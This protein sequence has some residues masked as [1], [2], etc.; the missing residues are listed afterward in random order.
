[1]DVR[2]AAS[3]VHRQP[4]RRL[5]GR[6]STRLLKLAST[7]IAPDELNGRA[8][9]FSPHPDDE[10]LGC[11]GTILKKV[12]SGATVTLVHMTDGGASTDL[13]AR[14]ELVAMRKREC[15]SA[16]RV[17]GVSDTIF[18]EYADG[19]LWDSI[20]PATD[21]V[22]EI[23][24][25]LQPAQVF[26]PYCREPMKQAADHVA[27]TKIVRAALERVGRS[28]TVWEYPIWAWLHWPWVRLRQPGPLMRTKHVLWN[29]GYLLF[30]ARSL[31][32]WRRRVEIA[33]VLDE[34]REAIAQHRSQTERI[35]AHPGYM[36]LGDVCHG[37]FLEWFMQ[38][39]EYFRVYDYP[40]GR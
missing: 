6:A 13:I 20:S 39:C 25:R 34:K 1:M 26:V 7:R 8:L 40:A 27:A 28:V 29:S 14:E 18:L 11:G 23:I 12:R 19:K 31:L 22:A 9:V 24:K 4:A 16:A 30:G 17:L 10:S 21:R 3:N 15:L 36:T 5:A 38:D 33:D 35:V 2:L 32:E 37:E